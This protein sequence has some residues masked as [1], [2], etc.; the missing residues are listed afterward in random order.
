[1]KFI[2]MIPDDDIQPKYVVPIINILHTVYIVGFFI[3][4]YWHS[5]L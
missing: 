5:Q 2:C 1:M 4:I 3:L